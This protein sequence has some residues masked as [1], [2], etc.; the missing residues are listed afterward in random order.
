MT[1]DFEPADV[2]GDCPA[3]AHG[4]LHD[5]AA[6]RC[7]V[8]GK[9]EMDYCTMCNLHTKFTDQELTIWLLRRDERRAEARARRPRGRK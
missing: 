5:W 7:R 2:L 8:S 1:H 4:G 6:H 3:L 9:P